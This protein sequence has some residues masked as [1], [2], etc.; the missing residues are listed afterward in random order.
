MEKDVLWWMFGS[1]DF[2]LWQ[3]SFCFLFYNSMICWGHG[4]RLKAA[5]LYITLQSWAQ[6]WNDNWYLKNT[7]CFLFLIVTFQR[8]FQKTRWSD[9]LALFK[10][11]FELFWREFVITTTCAN[12]TRFENETRCSANGV[13]GMPSTMFRASGWPLDVTRPYTR[14]KQQYLLAGQSWGVLKQAVTIGS[15]QMWK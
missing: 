3:F 10:Y 7:F 13:V 8:T 1:L 12:L 6:E 11:K 2:S 15:A 5:M 9:L 14:R 4:C